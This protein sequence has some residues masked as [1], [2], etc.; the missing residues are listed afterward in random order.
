M[1]L[2]IAVDSPEDAARAARFAHRVELCRDL[3]SHGFTPDPEVVAAVRRAA[4]VPLA[5]LIRPRAD[6]TADEAA[7]ALMERQIEGSLAAGA[8]ALVIGVVDPRGRVDAA[9][10]ARLA[11]AC[12]GAAMVFHRAFDLV[13][14]Q[15]RAVR[16]LSDLGF[17][18]VMCSGTPGLDHSGVQIDARLSRLARVVDAAEGRIT[19]T[20]CGGV[21]ADNAPLFLAVTPD[22]HSSCRAPGGSALDADHASALRSVVDAGL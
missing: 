6:A 18:R 10:C 8:D 3:A 19:V 22:I 1:P 20:A 2:E 12:G 16:Q 13:A 11:R 7:L 17:A 9:A 15:P 4:R 14:D 21:R 5:V